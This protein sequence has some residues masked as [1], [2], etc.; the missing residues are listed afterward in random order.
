MGNVTNI[1]NTHRSIGPPLF[2]ASNSPQ[3]MAVLC[4]LLSN[5]LQMRRKNNLK[6]Q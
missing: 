4:K 2:N 6:E 1:G 5:A 3:L